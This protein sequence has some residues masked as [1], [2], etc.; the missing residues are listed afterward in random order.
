MTGQLRRWHIYP[1]PEALVRHVA[2][3][4]TR[5]AAEAR[6]RTGRFD[7]VLAGGTTPRALYE[8]LAAEHAGNARW[9]VWFG[10]ERCLG[11]D[12][13]D[14]NETMARTAW[15][16]D[17]DI[18]GGQIHAVPPDPDPDAAAGRYAAALAGVDAFDL[19]LLGMG[20]D[21]HTAS[22]F[23]GQPGG[24]ADDAPD[25][26]A[27]RDAPKPPPERVTLSARRLGRARQVLVLATG[28]GKRDAVARWRRGDDL[29]V[30]RI[31]PPG[32][33]DVFLDEGAWASGR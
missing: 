1:D 26:L 6:V 21:G 15:L 9:H 27:V 24:F 33:V 29:P 20:E 19:V 28:P 10:D 7:I 3:A 11:A 25:A 30:A 17:S 18:P 31:T 14:R 12:D 4:V 32:G 16:D 2:G 5:A 8:R 23:P 13:P 22:L